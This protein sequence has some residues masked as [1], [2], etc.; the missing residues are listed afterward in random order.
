MAGG[1]LNHSGFS[2]LWLVWALVSM[3][4]HVTKCNTQWWSAKWCLFTWWN[5]WIELD[6]IASG[7]RFQIKSCYE[8]SAWLKWNKG[9]VFVSVFQIF[10]HVQVF[11][12]E[13]FPD[14]EFCYQAEEAAV[15]SKILERVFFLFIYYL[16]DSWCSFCAYIVSMLSALLMN[17]KWRAFLLYLFN[18]KELLL[19]FS[20][21]SV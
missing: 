21:S 7:C 6:L 4:S 5:A 15:I 13:R 10:G 14:F 8:I 1:W 11:E 19:P 20:L 12:N 17:T 3:S 18:F 2:L 16:M 9:V